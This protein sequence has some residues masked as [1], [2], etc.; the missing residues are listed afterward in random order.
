M[1]GEITLAEKV[2]LLRRAKAVLFPIDWPEPF[3]L[4]MTEA[5]ACGTPVIATPRGSVP[6]VVEDGVTGWI[7]DVEDYPGAGRGAAR[8]ALRDRSPR[9]PRP[10]SAPV[11]QGGHGRGVRGRVRARRVRPLNPPLLLLAAERPHRSPAVAL[12]GPGARRSSSRVAS[13]GHRNRNGAYLLVPRPGETC[14][15]DPPIRISPDTRRRG[16]CE[17]VDEGADERQ[18]H[19]AAVRVSGNDERVAAGGDLGRRVR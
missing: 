4:V 8:Q 15:N 17:F 6:E 13:G 16:R 5:M 2:S 7:V 19:L 11:L 1:L 14:T 3:G 10:G 9:V 18:P 12:A